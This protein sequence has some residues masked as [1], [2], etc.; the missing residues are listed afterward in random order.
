MGS[1]FG[2]KL[3]CQTGNFASYSVEST[4]QLKEYFWGFR[5]IVITPTGAGTQYIVPK[6]KLTV[7]GRV[8]IDTE[9]YTCKDARF[10]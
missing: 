3:L 7:G 5:E 10:Y 4:A 9:R 2:N 8:L 6:Y 1:S